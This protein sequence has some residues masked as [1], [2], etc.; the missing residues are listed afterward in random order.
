MSDEGRKIRVGRLVLG[1]LTCLALAPVARAADRPAPAWQVEG[2][3]GAVSDYRYRGL[4]LSDG[5][6]A[7]QAG[8]T[9]SH[10]SGVYGDLYLSTIEEYGVGADG[11]GAKVEATLTVGWSGSVAGFDIDA[12]VAAYG[13]P[14]GAD[15]SYLEVPLQLGQ[16]R[17]PVT[18]TVGAA[19]APRGQAAIGDESNR[20]VWA[21]LDLAP[22]RS[23]VS[24][25]SRLGREAGAYAP[26]GKT[27]WLLGA[28]LPLGPATLSVDYVDSDAGAAA[29]L[30]GLFA[31]F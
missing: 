4:S 5:K 23:P 14:D 30:V 18:W 19:W 1:A 10:A 11:D 13:Y 22:A 31:T 25:R 20:Y 15:V 12:G 26:G 8:L 9:A 2:T 6:P 3:L 17:G 29:V 28:S 27:D 21:G 24:F 7:G 16:T